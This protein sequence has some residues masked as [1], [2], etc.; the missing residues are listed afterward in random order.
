MLYYGPRNILTTGLRDETRET[1][2][3]FRLV[4]EVVLDK[5]DAAFPEHFVK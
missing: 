3:N 2:T 4:F 1:Y 5:K